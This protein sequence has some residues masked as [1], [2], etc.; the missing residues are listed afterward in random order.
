MICDHG[1]VGHRFTALAAQ[2]DIFDHLAN[3][4]RASGLVYRGL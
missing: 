3:Y 2:H 4:G 1:R